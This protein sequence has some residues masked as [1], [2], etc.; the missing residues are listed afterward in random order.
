MET[1]TAQKRRLIRE[2]KGT[3]RHAET[4]RSSRCCGRYRCHHPSRDGKIYTSQYCS[5]LC[6]DFDRLEN[7]EL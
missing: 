5:A 6:P 7:E 2:T 4:L 3:C 1:K